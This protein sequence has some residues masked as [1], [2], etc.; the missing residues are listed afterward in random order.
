MLQSKLTKRN[1]CVISTKYYHTSL[2]T[3]GQVKGFDWATGCYIINYGNKQREAAHSS[4]P[5]HSEFMMV[6]LVYLAT[7]A[8]CVTM[9]T[10]ETP[11]RETINEERQHYWSNVSFNVWD[12]KQ[13]L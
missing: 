7:V 5:L 2:Q 11:V 1:V 10:T 4:L 6:Q 9:A 3:I 12:N 8:P 13:R